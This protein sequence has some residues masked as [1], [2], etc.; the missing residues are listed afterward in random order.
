M[1]KI[2][3]GHCWGDH[4]GKEAPKVEVEDKAPF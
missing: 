4:S 2:I 1:N 3:Y